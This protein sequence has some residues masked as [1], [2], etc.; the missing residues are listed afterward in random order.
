M[1]YRWL[2]NTA[3]LYPCTIQ[4][5]TGC[6]S[7]MPIKRP[8]QVATSYTN[9]P[10]F[11]NKPRKWFY[12]I[13]LEFVWKQT[14]KRTPRSVFALAY[15]INADREQLTWPN[16]RLWNQRLNWSAQTQVYA[17]K[18]TINLSVTFPQKP[19][20]TN[21]DK[22]FQQNLSIDNK[23]FFFFS[24]WLKWFFEHAMCKAV[25]LLWRFV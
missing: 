16:I 25:I 14:S 11:F 2:G 18:P 17:L 7:F 6:K 13:I 15:L 9:T 12:F 19:W 5:C 1:T 23:Y 20:R 3:A 8:F 10:T 24:F 4:V 22:T 21:P